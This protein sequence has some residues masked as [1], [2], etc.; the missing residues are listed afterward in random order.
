[1]FINYYSNPDKAQK[2]SKL[3]YIRSNLPPDTKVY[4][5]LYPRGTIISRSIIVNTTRDLYNPS[6]DKVIKLLLRNSNSLNRNY[7]KKNYIIE[8]TLYYNQKYYYLSSRAY[9]KSI[10]NKTYFN[11]LNS[12][13]SIKYLKG[14]T[15][16]KADLYSYKADSGSTIVT[17]IKREVIIVGGAFNTL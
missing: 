1:F 16:Y 8:Y 17:V 9:L 11:N 14:A 6:K 4:R 7:F 15:L 10:I 5:I 13:I 3:Y 12:I 2:D